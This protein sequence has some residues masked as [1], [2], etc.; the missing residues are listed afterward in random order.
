VSKL[1]R[2]LGY[3]REP[4]PDGLEII[5]RIQLSHPVKCFEDLL[6][7][8]AFEEPTAGALEAMDG[9]GAIAGANALLARLSDVPVEAIQRLRPA[10]YAKA[11]DL[12]QGWYGDLVAAGAK[13][14]QGEFGG[15]AEAEGPTEPKTSGASSDAA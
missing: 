6:H 11:I 14:D 5:E 1:R 15:L 4:R 12:L 8:L 2:V 3:A 13:V 9:K 7:E 10:D